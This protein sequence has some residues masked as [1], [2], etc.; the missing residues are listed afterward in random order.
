MAEFQVLYWHDIP[1]QVRAGD[2]RNRV[3]HELAPRFQTAIDQVAMSAGLIGT[4]EYLDGFRW[5]E[6]QERDGPAEEVVATVAAELEASYPEIDWQK[7]VKDIQAKSAN[8][9]VE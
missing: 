9:E 6:A 1:L 3:S 7:A 8:Q 2:R 4:D 5:S